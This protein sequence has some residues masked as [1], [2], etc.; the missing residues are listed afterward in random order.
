MR[1]VEVEREKDRE[2]KRETERQRGTVHVSLVA[3]SAYSSCMP[4]KM[5]NIFQ[6]VYQ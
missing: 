3:Y 4:V 1:E 5:M 2:R 6:M